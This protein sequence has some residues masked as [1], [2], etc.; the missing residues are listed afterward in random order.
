MRQVFHSSPWIHQAA[1]PEII[2][3]FNT[4]GRWMRL[5]AGAAIFNGGE[6]GE[7]ALVLSGLGA[8]SFQDARGKNHI[9]TLVPPGRLMGDVD[10]L[11]ASTVNITDIALRETEVRL[12]GRD[13]FLGFLDANPDLQRKHTINVIKDHESD[14]EGMIANFTLTAP[15]RIMTLFASLAHNLH[16]MPEAGFYRLEHV[17]T[18]VEI[19]QIVSVA[20]PTVSSILNQWLTDKLIVKSDKSLLVSERLFT[21]LYDWTNVGAIPATRIR[22]RR[23]KATDTTLC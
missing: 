2:R 4:H 11:C 14:M 1:D 5:N 13:Q 6:N 16:P 20:R 22:K 19:S 15:E 18:T 10:G 17:L 23:R 8:F 9:F 7:I 3:L 12:L 21:D